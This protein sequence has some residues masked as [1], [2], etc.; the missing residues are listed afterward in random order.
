MKINILLILILLNPILSSAQG[1]LHWQQVDSAFGPLPA[2]VHLYETRSQVDTAPFH[3][4]YLVADLH[5]PQLSL[6]AD[7]SY[8]RR[9]TPAQFYKKDHKPLAVVNCTFF[10]FETNQNLNMVMQHGKL[11]SYNAPVK[12]HG[13]DSIHKY[14]A[15]RSAV[16]V[17][18][19]GKPSIAW[20]YTDSSKKIPI[21]FDAPVPSLSTCPEKQRISYRKARRGKGLNAHG[22]K[23]K[24]ESAVGGGPM[25]LF[26]GQ[27]QITSE[28]EARFAG[29]GMLEKHP[30]TAA[31]YTSDGKFIILVIE[32]RNPKAGGATL[33]QEALILQSLGC[34]RALNLDGGGS[35]CLLVNGQETILPADKGVERPIPAAMIIG[36]SK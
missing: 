27:V 9:L 35:S 20:V 33:N 32:G 15:F 36:N 2:S 1:S 14:H 29:K 30:R 7:T 10:S 16:G 12:G 19:D 28:E 4:F 34:E 11:V 21:A 23:W 31:G 3:A 25:L 5:D 6:T 18:S 17:S 22:H 26:N 8:R 13:A 24:M